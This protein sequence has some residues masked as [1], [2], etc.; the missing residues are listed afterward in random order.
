MKNRSPSTKVLFIGL[1]ESLAED[2]SKALPGYQAAT[3]PAAFDDADVCQATLQQ[4]NADVVFCSARDR[5]LAVL[6][7]AA[8]RVRPSPAVVVVT[9]HPEVNDWLDVLEAGAADYC[10]APF[11][12][13]HLGWI[14]QSN[15]PIGVR[16]MA[17]GAV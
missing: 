9:R 8:G 16:Q 1:D 13:Q 5:D 12:S 11:E 4:T 14:L 2:L 15:L 3:S 17:G 10:A 7:Q 6:L